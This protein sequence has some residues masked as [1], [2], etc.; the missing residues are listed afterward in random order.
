MLAIAAFLITSSIITRLM[1]T[2]RKQAEEALSSVKPV[3]GK[4]SL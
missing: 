3:F 2:V 4:A 1:A